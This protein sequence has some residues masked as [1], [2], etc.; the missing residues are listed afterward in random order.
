M[1]K[2]TKRIIHISS[3]SIPWGDSH[4]NTVSVVSRG[5]PE[6]QILMFKDSENKLYN[7]YT[8]KGFGADSIEGEVGPE[9]SYLE[10]P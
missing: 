9:T 8:I 1:V 10:F 6:V 4:L 5:V 7:Q 2:D 3:T